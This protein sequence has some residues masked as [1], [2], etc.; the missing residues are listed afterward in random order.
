[1]SDQPPNDD[2]AGPPVDAKPGDTWSLDPRSRSGDSFAG[3]PEGA[4]SVTVAEVTEGGGVAPPP[5]PR[6]GL[7]VAGVALAAVLVLAGVAGAAAFMLLRGSSEAILGKVPSSA[8]VVVTANLD[9]AASQKMNL[10]HIASRF[11]ALGGQDQIRQQLNQ[12]L[13]GLL[14]DVG[15]SHEDVQWVGSEVGLY[16]D[17]KSTQETSYAILIATDD[18]S[19]AAASLQKF[20]AGLESQGATFHSSDHDGAQITVSATAPPV[21]LRI[22]SNAQMALRLAS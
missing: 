6:R 10:L 3:P 13:D 17:V 22:A 14:R 7:K 1:M 11:P 8:D 5:A 2:T 12:T 18:Q 9:P 19:A 21:R 16:V 15:M 4:L 20:R